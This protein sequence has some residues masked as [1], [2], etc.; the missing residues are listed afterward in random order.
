MLVVKYNGVKKRV[1]TDWNEITVK[2]FHKLYQVMFEYEGKD[3]DNDENNKLNFLRD[4]TT[5]LLNENRKYV[6]LMDLKDIEHLVSASQNLLKEYK[7]QKLSH[8]THK[9]VKYYFPTD[10]RKN[11]FGEYIECSA[12]ETS[13]KL[14]KNG[15]FDV[16]TEM[17][18]RLCKKVDEI[19]EYLDEKTIK[20]RAKLFEDLTMDLVLEFN[21]FL[22][23]QQKVLQKVFRTYGV[24]KAVQ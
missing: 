23:S 21:F 9:D 11:T 3:I 6:E 12:L 2:Q 8:F 7:Y 22:L 10:I 17:M 13:S 5:F 15:K 4:Y 1:P 14:L 20:E 18:A 16:I 24:G 19:G